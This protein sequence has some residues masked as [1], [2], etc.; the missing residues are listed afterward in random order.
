MTGQIVTLFNPRKDDWN[1]H[2]RWSANGLTLLGKT[3][4]AE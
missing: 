3:P 2:F 4:S 1:E